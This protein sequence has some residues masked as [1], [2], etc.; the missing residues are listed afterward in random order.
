MGN[1]TSTSNA[2]MDVVNK[3]TTNVMMSNS[4]KCAQDNRQKLDINISNIKSSNCPIKIH[5]IQ[6]TVVQSP[7]FTCLSDSSQSA[8]LQTQLQTAIKQQADAAVSGIG[9]SLNSQAVSNATTKLQNIVNTNVNI[10]NVSSCVQANLQDVNTIIN[11]IESG[12][13][14][15]CATG[16]VGITDA[17]I[18]K[19]MLDKCVTDIS[20]ISQTATQAA[21][22]NCTSKNTALTSAIND[23]ANDLSQSATSKNTGVDLFASLASVGGI[24]VPIIISVVLCIIIVLSFMMME[25]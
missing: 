14:S 7:S 6:Q 24:F 23:I 21:V 9:G 20:D 8:D 1:Q 19:S 3:A 5:G 25:L 16:C 2:V 12:C 10:S 13:P 17:N 15:Y 4:S 18:C 22:V 11:N